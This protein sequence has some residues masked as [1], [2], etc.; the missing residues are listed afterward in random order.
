MKSSQRK[1]SSYPTIIRIN[2]ETGALMKEM[3]EEIK[4][5][6]GDDKRNFEIPVTPR[7]TPKTVPMKEGLYN[8]INRSRGLLFPPPTDLSATIKKVYAPNVCPISTIANIRVCPAYKRPKSAYPSIPPS[9]LV[10]RKGK[11]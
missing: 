1:D 10:T 3:E 6:T 5:P 7:I 11:N 2:P 4:E 8:A 9:K